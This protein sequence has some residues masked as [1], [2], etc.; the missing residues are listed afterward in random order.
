MSNIRTSGI[1]LYHNDSPVQFGQAKANGAQFA[2]C[3]ASQGVG[4]IDPMYQAYRAQAKAAAILFGA[5]MFFDPA[6]DPIQQAR[7]FINAA[8]PAKGDLVPALDVETPGDN[9]GANAHAC[10]EEIKDLTGYWPILYSG[11]SF[12]QE[13]LKAHF[14]ECPL[15]I[16]RYGHAPVTTCEIWQFTDAS[17]EP[18]TSH[19]L[20]GNV[21][22]GTIEDLIAKHTIK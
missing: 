19:Q 11:D 22:F 16:A 9:V 3:K 21:Y 4:M 10:A 12:Y 14:T 2:I 15:W 20:D 6:A 7:H 1:D 17:R 8:T 13:N 18:G 5:Y